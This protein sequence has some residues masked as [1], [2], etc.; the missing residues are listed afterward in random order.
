MH[1]MIIIFFLFVDK[2]HNNNKKLF[3]IYRE[4]KVNVAGVR[5]AFENGNY[6]RYPR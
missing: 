5:V 4:I 3:N 1:K 2:L 6:V